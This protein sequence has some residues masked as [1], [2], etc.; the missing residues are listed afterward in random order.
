MLPLSP[1]P[2]RSS[3]GNSVESVEQPWVH[4]EDRGSRHCGCVSAAAVGDVVNVDG[5]FLHRRGECFHDLIPDVPTSLK[6]LDMSWDAAVRI[7]LAPT[8]W[9]T[10][11]PTARWK[12]PSLFASTKHGHPW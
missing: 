7:G 8:I 1:E 12:R 5:E 10:Q 2:M 3:S 6:S 9:Q 11:V 4:P